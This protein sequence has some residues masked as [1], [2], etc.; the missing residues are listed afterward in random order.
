MSKLN[1]DSQKFNFNLQQTVVAQFGLN[2]TFFSNPFNLKKKLITIKLSKKLILNNLK[3][4]NIN[5]TNFNYEKLYFLTNGLLFPEFCSKTS[6][7]IFLIKQNWP[8]LFFFIYTNQQATS[9]NTRQII[10]KKIFD[11]KSK[12]EKQLKKKFQIITKEGWMYLPLI[13][14]NAI[15]NHQKYFR[16]GQLFVDDILIP[17]LIILFECIK[18]K[19]KKL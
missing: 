1:F 18:W 5:L 3:I 11:D 8:S 9:K 19:K 7:N 10:K 15:K 13:G 4:K 16:P 6:T 2:S 12:I 17:Q 14:Q